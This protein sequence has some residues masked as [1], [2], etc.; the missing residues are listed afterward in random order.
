[1]I[2]AGKRTF[3]A[4]GPAPEKTS[5]GITLFAFRVWLS[6][7]II[8]SERQLPTEARIAPPALSILAM[9][10]CLLI[11]QSEKGPMAG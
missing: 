11:A 5:W 7:S 2:R 3:A 1:M 9:L 6:V 10:S 4:F 8:V